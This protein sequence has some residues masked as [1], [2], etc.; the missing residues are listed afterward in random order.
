MVTT[1]EEDIPS[2]NELEIGK[3]STAEKRTTALGS[4]RLQSSD[5]SEHEP[6]TPMGTF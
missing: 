5:S 3:I 1:Y 6:Q 2:E 4:S